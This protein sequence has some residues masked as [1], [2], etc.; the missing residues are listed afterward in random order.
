MR[1]NKEENNKYE[2]LA[3]FLDE[4]SSSPD[5]KQLSEEEYRKLIYLWD[6][7][8]PPKSE[9]E[10]EEVWAKTLQKIKKNDA[11]VALSPRRRSVS[12]SAWFVGIAASIVLLIGVAFFLTQEK[13]NLDEGLKMKQYMLANTSADDVKEVTLVVSEKKKIEIA[14]NSQVAYSATGQVQVNSDK[15][16]D[17]AASEKKVE[18]DKEEYNQIIVP[19]G[20]RSMIVLADNSKIWINSG[21]KVIYPRAFKEGKRQ[22]FVEGEVY[23]KVARNEKKPFVVSTSSFEVEVLGTSFNVAA[24][25]NSEASVVLVEGAVNVKD[26]LERHIKMQPNERVALNETGI[27]KKEKVDA[28]EYIHWVDGVWVLDGKPLKEVLRYLTEYYGQLV[29]CDPSIENEPFYGKLFLND[30][31]DKVL[32][33]IKETLPATLTMKESIIHKDN[34]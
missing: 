15:L 11:A 30:D 19:K 21:S 23:L 33:S 26:C 29:Y 22:I 24:Y 14:N 31:L 20:R 7:C 27:T 2:S 1:E 10:T 32:E 6:E 16:D 13:E 4:R 8:H 18:E 28:L 3:S 12:M 34:I 25:K 9:T 17:S 5:G